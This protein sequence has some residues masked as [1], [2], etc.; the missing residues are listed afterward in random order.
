[1]FDSANC[2]VKVVQVFVD[3]LRTAA[4]I[5]HGLLDD[6]GTIKNIVMNFGC[7]LLSGSDAIVVILITVCAEG[8]ELPS[9]FPSQRMTEV[10]SRVALRIVGNCLPVVCGQQIF[11]LRR[12]RCRLPW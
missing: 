5:G 2:A 3:I 7:R 12:L 11:P 9:L 6:I 1:M 4:G 10:M 8:L